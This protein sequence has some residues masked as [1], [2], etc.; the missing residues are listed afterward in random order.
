MP[1]V[2]K[3]K[4]G[5]R[6][7]KNFTDETLENAL[8]AIADGNMTIRRA[9]R[10]FKI[11]YGT[12]NNKF[13]GRHGAAHG[14]PT[15]FTAAEETAFVNAITKSSDWGFPL[16]KR[17][18]QIF[19]KSY[20]DRKGVVEPR[21]V[22]NLPGDDW[23]DSFLKRHKNELAQRWAANIKRS[24]AAITKQVIKDYFT[25]VAEV[26]QG[27]PPSHLFNYDESNLS[28]DPGK[29]KAIFR[30][31]VKY[32][33]RVVNFSKSATSIM[34]CGSASGVLLPPFVIYKG[35]HL[36]NTWT[37]GGAKGKPCCSQPCCSGGTRYSRTQHGWIDTETFA[38]WFESSFLPHARRL[39][40]K[41]VLI[42]DNLSSHLSADVIKRCEENN[43]AF[44][45]LPPHST[46]LLQPLDVAFFRPLKMA[47]RKV[48]LS[49]KTENPRGGVVPKE[50]FPKLLKRT[51]EMMDEVEGNVPGVSSAIKRNLIA[52]FE[53]TGLCPVSVDRVLKK[54]P[55]QDNN[56]N[57]NELVADTLTD[58]LKKQR[59]SGQVAWKGNKK[60][61]KLNVAPG[62]SITAENSSE[63]EEEPSVSAP[64]VQESDVESEISEESEVEPQ[65]RSVTDEH[66]KAG[67]YALIKFE[68]AGKRKTTYYRYVCRIEQVSLPDEILVKG[69]KSSVKK[70]RQIFRFRDEDMSVVKK[71]DIIALLPEPVKE[72]T[73]NR[74]EYKFHF[75]IDVKEY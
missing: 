53:A 29:M 1:R 67:Q 35:E 10:E 8:Q 55:D 60:R 41:K 20:L 39:D 7:Y 63:D 27:V 58:F 52:G 66:I 23:A 44:V 19:V 5:S 54:I 3:R 49:W 62:K 45:C 75:K 30:R 37:E 74:P 11:P 69:M 70:E 38:D 73:E 71:E 6:Q 36:W 31:G 43:V 42:G 33:E 18:L 24:R 46:H 26:L 22:N 4:I 21:F 65:Y 2:Y 51:L 64:V 16:N 12:L 32:P 28:D 47:W 14:G 25:N 9:S 68:G 57:P 59:E 17:D 48:L 40:G 50:I 56:E 34:V 72:G 61:K 15:V 13:H